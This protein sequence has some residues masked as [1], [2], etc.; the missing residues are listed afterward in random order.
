M[1]APVSA[2]PN[3]APPD[4]RPHGILNPGGVR[5]NLAAAEFTELAL[6][7]GEGFLAY[8]GALVARTGERTGRSPLDR[9]VVGNAQTQPDVWWGRHNQ[10]LD[11]AA[12]ER[13]REKVL[14][15]LQ[16]R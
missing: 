4:L 13:L 7:R 5:A 6:A 12:F 8:R 11:R 9:Y 16:G 15:Y 3:P 14:A 10:P 2:S 1:A